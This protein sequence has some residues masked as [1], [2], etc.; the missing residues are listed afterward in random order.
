[1]PNLLLTRKCVRRCPYCFAAQYMS[2]STSDVLGW[3]DFIYVL[4]FYERNGHRM[5]SMLGGEPTTHPHAT[6]LMDYA[7]QRGFDVRVFTSGIVPGPTRERIAE[8]LQTH[9]QKRRFMFIVNVNAPSETPES[10]CKAQVE[11]LKLVKKR[12]SLSFNIYQPNFDLGFAFEYIAD[13]A[14]MPSLRL[15]LA[16]PVAS[17]TEGNAHLAPSDYRAVADRLASFFPSFDERNVVPDFDCGFP[18]CM[19]S[20][21]RL[22]ALVRLR[23]KFNWTCAPIFDIGP[24]L[25]IW[26]CFPLSGMRSRSLYDYDTIHQVRDDMLREVRARRGGRK[27]VFPECHTCAMPRRR[28]CG[29]GCVAYSIE[30]VRP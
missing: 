21:E 23:A 18:I 10:E 13:Y 6:Q 22:G 28:L 19:F 1:M 14:L 5:V 11:F 25:D 30:G 4:D 15:G 26:P 24:D 27:G 2:E 17:A 9:G 7:L 16:H 12:A 20:D 8:L 29:G 3:N